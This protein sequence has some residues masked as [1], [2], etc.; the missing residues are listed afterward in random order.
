MTKHTILFVAANPTGTDRLVLD[1]EARAIEVELER[2]GYRDQFELVTRGTVQLLDTIRELRRKIAPAYLDRRAEIRI[3]RH[4]CL[5]HGVPMA[6]CSLAWRTRGET[7]D[8]S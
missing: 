8:V 7:R 6:L 1:R 5:T 2:S 3:F 4:R